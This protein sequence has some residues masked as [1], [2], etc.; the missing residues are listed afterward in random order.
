LWT[1]LS[2]KEKSSKFISQKSWLI[3]YFLTVYFKKIYTKLCGTKNKIFIYNIG[4]KCLLLLSV[5][6]LWLLSFFKLNYLN[7]NNKLAY[8]YNIKV[9][10]NKS[11]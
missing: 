4:K 11:K 10:S 9:L 3:L 6:I 8:F 7:N 1:N 2:Y 5:I